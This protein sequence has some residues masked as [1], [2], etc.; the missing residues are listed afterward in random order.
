[1]KRPPG[2]AFPSTLPDQTQTLIK[3][4]ALYPAHLTTPDQGLLM[5]ALSHDVYYYAVAATAVGS[6]MDQWMSISG[7]KGLSQIAVSS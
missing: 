4:F 7:S 5:N 6:Y 3:Y 2:N 1:M